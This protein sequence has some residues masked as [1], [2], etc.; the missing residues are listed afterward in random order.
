MSHFET[1]ENNLAQETGGLSCEYDQ[2]GLYELTPAESAQASEL[3]EQIYDE[4]SEVQSEVQSVQEPLMVAYSD[5]PVDASSMNTSAPF[6]VKKSVQDAVSYVKRRI[7]Y[8]NTIV[9]LFV[10]L[11]VVYIL[12]QQK[13]ISMPVNLPSLPSLP[14]NV[15]TALGLDNATSSFAASSV[16][17]LGQNVARATL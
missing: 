5:S 13:I 1:E 7:N 12:Y 14:S 15:V 6:S 3:D 2:D 10:V 9:L 4:Q 16:S 8:T 11:I 17:S